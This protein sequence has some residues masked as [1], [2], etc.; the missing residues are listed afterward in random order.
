MHPCDDSKCVKIFRAGHTDHLSGRKRRILA[1][2]EHNYYNSLSKRGVAGGHI[3]G[4]YGKM[5]IQCDGDVRLAGIFDLIRNEDGQVS[6]TLDVELSIATDGEE[7]ADAMS[8]LYGYLLRHKIISGFKMPNIVVQR[9]RCPSPKCVLIDNI[10]NTDFVPIQ[11]VIMWIGWQQQKYGV[12]G[13][14]F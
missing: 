1:Q 3:A 13:W 8:E 2:R 14:R 7:L 4:Y 6:K 9:A 11:Y 5:L 12:V 10:G